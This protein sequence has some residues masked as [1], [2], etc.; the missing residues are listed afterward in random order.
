LITLWISIGL[1]AGALHIW[2]ELRSDY[3]RQLFPSWNSTLRA[4]SPSAAITLLLLYAIA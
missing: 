2:Q 4:V 3:Q 1:A